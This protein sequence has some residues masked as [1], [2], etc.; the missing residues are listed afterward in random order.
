[1]GYAMLRQDHKASGWVELIGSECSD[2]VD[3]GVEGRSVFG[4]IEGA[5]RLDMANGGFGHV[6]GLEQSLIGQRQGQGFPSP[7]G[8]LTAYQLN[9]IKPEASFFPFLSLP[10]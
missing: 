2:E 1:M 4:K 5:E 6:P 3:E 8:R 7:P 10:V 9:P